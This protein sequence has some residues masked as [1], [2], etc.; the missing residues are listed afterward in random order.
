MAKNKNKFQVNN[1]EFDYVERPELDMSDSY[2]LAKEPLDWD[3]SVDG[4][5]NIVWDIDEAYTA[6]QQ[7]EDEISLVASDVD[8]NT[9]AIQVN[10]DNI[11]LRV[12]K[13]DVINQINI[14]DE[15][16][17]IEWNNIELNWNTTVDWT[18]SVTS[19]NAD[20]N[21]ASADSPWGRYNKWLDTNDI[22]ETKSKSSYTGV[23][24]DGWWLYG[25]NK[26]NKTFE[27]SNSDGSAFFKWDIGASNI[28]ATTNVASGW[29]IKVDNWNGDYVD[30]YIDSND[31]LP[32]LDFQENTVDVGNIIGNSDA[33]VTIA[34]TIYNLQA[35]EATGDFIWSNIL[36][37]NGLIVDSNAVFDSS[38][39][40]NRDTSSID[41]HLR[42][43]N[44][45]TA[46]GKLYAKAD[47]N[48]YWEPSWGTAI[49]LTWTEVDNNYDISTWTYVDSLDVASED[50]A[51]TGITFN[52][53][54]SKLYMVGIEYTSVHEYDL[55]TNYDISTW[56]F[57]DS[58]D[59]W[60]EATIPTWIAFN[61]TGSKLYMVGDTDK[62]VY[63]YN[64]A[65]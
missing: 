12:E 65:N 1:Y 4:W 55:S 13:D 61:D 2:G 10:S 47:N 63:E 30:I 14:S 27:I 23:I 34:G 37:R 26:W 21:Y 57:V 8:D 58:L 49:K 44:N 15:G 29:S 60:G 41:N 64:L 42:L 43:F 9:A 24:M 46:K 56:T 53:T 3:T 6:I 32:K 33:S 38:I 48:L 36:A 20:F 40:I 45:W 19:S 54:G 39:S 59:V 11:N 62:K 7:N 17:L 16:V 52:D 28:T 50:S 51:P 31:G 18:F 5:Q 35:I 25:Y 22:I